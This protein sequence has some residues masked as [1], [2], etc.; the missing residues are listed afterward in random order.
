MKHPDHPETQERLREI[1]NRQVL[2][3]KILYRRTPSGIPYCTLDLP[4]KDLHDPLSDR[5]T[6]RIPDSNLA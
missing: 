1:Y 2:E 5:E 4:E 6:P 3:S